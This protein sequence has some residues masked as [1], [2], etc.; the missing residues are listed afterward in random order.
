M[1]CSERNIS[2]V[3]LS[4]QEISFVFREITQDSAE[5]E[6]GQ[7]DRVLISNDC[8]VKQW[9]RGNAIPTANGP[10]VTRADSLSANARISPSEPVIT[11]LKRQD[12]TS[13]A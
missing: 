5:M 2:N 6:T 3:F 8:G 9:E 12:Q 4:N 1:R 13:W 11:K 7:I 10:S